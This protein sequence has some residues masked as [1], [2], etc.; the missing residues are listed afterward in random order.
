MGVPSGGGQSL[1]H[2]QGRISISTEDVRR[3]QQEV[4]QAS[5]AMTTA[6]GAIGVSLTAAGFVQLATQAA[7]FA[8]ESEKVATA[9]SRQR[10]AAENLAGSQSQ[11]NDLLETYEAAVGGSV[12]Q[13]SALENVTKLLSVGFADSAEELDQ[14]ARSIRGISL[15]LGRSEDFV[16]QN[17]I[18]ELFSQR[19]QRLDQLGL[20]Y[21]KVRQRADE[22]RA[23]DR[24]LTQEMAYQQAV[25]EQADERFG[26]LT[27][28]VAGQKTEAEQ[29]RDA[30]AD[31]RLE[32]AQEIKPNVEETSSALLDLLNLIN[33]VRD[34]N[35]EFQREAVSRRAREEGRPDP[36]GPIAS[37]TG[38]GALQ[39]E[40]A[41][42]FGEGGATAV[43][44][45]LE[46]RNNA[47]A[48][49]HRATL[50]IERQAADDR[51]SATRQYEEQRTSAI[52]DYER[53]IAREA[54]DF[55]IQRARAEQDYAIGL[56]RM[57]RDIAQREAQQFAD[58]ERTIS[59]ARTDAA[60]R[61]SERQIA[62]DERIA[63]TRSQANERIAELE[64]DFAKRR[65]RA[66]RDHADKLRDAAANLDAVAVR[67][68]Q[69]DFRN[70]QRDAQ[71]DF[72][73]RIQKERKN[74]E[75]RLEEL[76]K[77]HTK[78]N[79]DEAKALQKRIDDA[80]EAYQ[81][82]LEDARAADAQR[83]EDM[84][85][86]FQLR[87]ER[88]DEDR[89][90]R[91]ERLK[92]DHDDQLEEMARQHENRLI[93][94]SDHAQQ[95]RDR[96][97]T[98]FGHSLEALGV[99]VDAFI[100]ESE[101]ATTQAIAEF[102]R[103]LAHVNAA[104]VGAAQGPQPLNPLITPGSW[105]SLTGTVA[106]VASSVTSNS[107]SVTLAPGAIVI[108]GDGLNEQQVAAVV[109]EELANFFEG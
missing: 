11:L 78:Q 64:A 100:T 82:Q 62:L 2:A 8:V 19:G 94:I 108:N 83:I 45:F 49:W 34:A 51:L 63:E 59:D 43:D 17:L 77:A 80:N 28:T 35:A 69:R 65:E 61:A 79:A 84:A 41:R 87:K 105:P 97:N 81:R 48:E 23:A 66:Q 29:L 67:E 40:P 4:A 102:D 101:R 70:S 90:I 13:V 99:Y 33:R 20:Q 1:G 107:R 68:A 89:G 9:Y 31:M 86:D 85:A 72:D 56:Q 6:L 73:E 16:T 7:R 44:Q 18:L 21:D 93:Q 75:K 98:E 91:L 37:R 54:Q 46:E 106:P 10:A 25:L 32:L 27:R 109:I 3:A 71:E 74:E 58:L 50:D 5:R 104:F 12:S 39:R 92:Q 95:E 15:A 60:E 96:L 24:K 14:F 22:L 30:W 42:G 38:V 53:T 103:W 88:E 52:R 57:H 36:F 26:Q 47:I 55:A 76:N